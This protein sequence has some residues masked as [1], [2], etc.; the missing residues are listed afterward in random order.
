MAR[1][2]PNKRLRFAINNHPTKEFLDEFFRADTSKFKFE[3]S[4]LEESEIEA[5]NLLIRLLKPKVII[6]LPEVKVPQHIKSPDFVIDGITYEVKAPKS[7]RQ[8]GH[9]IHEG[10]KQIGSKGYIVMNACY[11]ERTLDKFIRESIAIAGQCRVSQ[12][13]LVSDHEIRKIDIKK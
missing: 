10:K 7:I 2:L 13:Y 11:C 1:I 9:R 3:Y 12:I 8:I 6:R 4:K 5:A